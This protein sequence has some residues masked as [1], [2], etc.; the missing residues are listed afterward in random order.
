MDADLWKNAIEHPFLEQCKDAFIPLHCF[1]WW[2][3]QDYGFVLNF[4][5]LS[6]AVLNKA[7]E[8]DKPTFANGL[9]ALD[10]ELKFYQASPTIWTWL[11]DLT[12]AKHNAL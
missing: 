3:Q 2:L 9:A 11:N 10:D 7:P 8:L 5:Q 12:I 1:N 6:K 4:Q